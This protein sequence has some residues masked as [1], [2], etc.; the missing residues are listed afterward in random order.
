MRRRG[1]VGMMVLLA[2]AALA[3][4]GPAL[5]ARDMY[6]GRFDCVLYTRAGERRSL[7]GEVQ[8]LEGRPVALRFSDGDG[9]RSVTAPI[10]GQGQARYFLEGGAMQGNGR[11]GRSRIYDFD[12]SNARHRTGTLR[13]DMITEPRPNVVTSRAILSIG[14]CQLAWDQP[15]S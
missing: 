14:I 8:Q 15:A 4:T 2:A 6:N 10:N 5:A 11:G 1:F 12:F 13:I 9:A 3:G 7:T